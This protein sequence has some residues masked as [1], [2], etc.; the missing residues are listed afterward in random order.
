MRARA[1]FSN[2]EP[3]T[4]VVMS[5]LNPP[6]PKSKWKPPKSSIPEV[7]TFLNRVESD[8]FSHTKRKRVDD[9]LSREERSALT[10]WRKNHLFN[11]ESDLII[12]Q[13]DKGN[14]FIIVDKDT[15]I[16][17]ANEQIQ[18]SS[19][20]VV[21]HDPTLDHV[22]R[23]K[24][25]TEK[26]L[27]KNEI[28]KNWKDFILNEEAQPGKN[29]PLYKT[30]K[31]NTPV[32][33]L[34]TGCNTA[35]ENLSRFLE[36]HSAPLTTQL[37]SRIKDTG[38]LLELIDVIN[39]KGLPEGTILVSFDV[40]N[41]FPN[42]DNERGIQTLR[43]A[44]DKRTSP[45]PSTECLIEALRL[46]L[47]CNNSTFNNTHLL[48]TNG[49]ATGA[50]NS[51]SYSDL[52]M[53]PID[54]AIFA[55]CAANFAELLFFGRYRDDCLILWV[56]SLERLHQFHDFIN[57][58]DPYLKFTIEIG[59]YFITVL[60]LRIGIH[61]GR[62]ITSVYSKPTDSHLYLQ[63]ESCHQEASINGIQKGVALRLRR[64]CSTLDEFDAKSK[65]YSA[66]LVAR[67]H[68]PYMVQSAFQSVRALTVSQARTKAQRSVNK[69]VIFSTKF[70]PLGPNVR[71]IIKKHSHI[72][73]NSV[74]ANELFPEGVMIASKR[75]Q[76]LK[77]LLTRAD[78][79]SIKSDLTDDLTGM[80][81][82]SCN[83][84][85]DSC[86]SFVM[87]TNKIKCS[88][89]GKVFLIRREFNCNSKYVVYCAICTKCLQQGVG[90][91][92]DWKPR[93]GNYKSHIKN[94]LRTCGI[95]KHFIDEC[96]DDTDPC[97]H[98]LFVIVDGLNNT[99]NLTTEQI[100]DLLLEKE[101]FWIGALVTQHSGMNCSHDWNRSRRSDKA[102]ASNLTSDP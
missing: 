21:N 79:Y 11:A 50:P 22:E 26:W 33:L 80:G 9:N 46:C 59:G 32:R 53:Q 86:G 17:K 44:Y 73:K 96:A 38:H 56:G 82:K 10:S 55:E 8:L 24:Q 4:E 31:D 48:Q 77:E 67:G 54:D 89:T 30:H 13:Q 68:N 27:E 3:E 39:L 90:S 100:D 78:P 25:W 14:R 2:K 69:K 60:D 12:R 29:S 58:L 91:T 15:D 42:I 37:P 64:I 49:T 41:M 52:A 72:L 87:E 66:Y 84:A 88:A 40:V 23:V 36:V 5:T 62:L 71:G 92:V 7:E 57:T 61:E 51:C 81:Y 74:K 65:E 70:N 19:F 63:A 93:L 6:K 18:R 83:R 20:Q 16:Q 94:G 85:C 76:N 35:I 98:L 34:T 95:A 43:T 47:Y 97:G 28:D 1:F 101:K 99:D 45:K 75:E 102:P